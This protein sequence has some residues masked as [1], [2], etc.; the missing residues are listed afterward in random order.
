[1]RFLFIRH[2]EPNYIKD[3]LT[4]TGRLQAEAAAKRLAGEGICEI[5]ASPLG[6]AQETA[7]YT[8]REL[9]LEITTLDFMREISWGGE[10][11]PDD[12]HIWTLADRMINEDNFD[13]YKQDWRE[14]PYFKNNT[15]MPYYEKI[16]SEIDT[17][18]KSNG[19]RHDGSRFF[20]EHAN[21]K[22]IALFS[23]GGS[24]GA[25]LAHILSL[26]FPYVLCVFPY[27]Y[28]SVISIDFPSQAGE[29]VHPRV[30]LFNDA[31]HIKGLGDELKLQNKS[32]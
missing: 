10:G 26:P 31:A 12:G 2:G 15:V 18:L 3:C 9:G 6:R 14:H 16:V 27:N 11:V 32:E 22:T 7:G 8:A 20:C 17:F 25:A 24:G 30:E 29:Y 28:T 23:H 21:D 4:P 5:Y 1:M 13:F 19:Y